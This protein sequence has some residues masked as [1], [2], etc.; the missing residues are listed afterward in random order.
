MAVG[1]PPDEFNTRGQ[2]WGLPPF[3]PWRLRAAGYGPFIETIRATLRHAG[4]LR[5]DHVMGLFRLFWIPRGRVAGRRAPTSATRPRELLD[6]V[7][8]ESHRAGAYV[9]GED[10]GTVEDE[11]REPSWPPATSCPT[12]C[13]GSRT[14]RRRSTRSRPWPPSPPTTCPPSP[15]CG[16]AP[17]S[18]TSA[19]S[20]WSRTRRP[21]RRCAR[22]LQEVTGVADD[23]PPDEVVAGTYAALADA[24]CMLLTATLDDA[25]GRGRAAQH[26]R[27]RRRVAQLVDRPARARWRS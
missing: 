18:T 11:V 20:A 25:L 6:I 4:G 16:P 2:D 13:C 27:H 3:D 9:V 23:A 22:R 12:G 15:A 10:L 1:A 17:T 7:A 19:G 21:P 14:G 5:L 24:P 26:A 8:L